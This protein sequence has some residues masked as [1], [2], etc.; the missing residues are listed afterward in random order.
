[1]LTTRSVP[2]P[3]AVGVAVFGLRLD[4]ARLAVADHAH[5]QHAGSHRFA[6]QM[7]GAKGLSQDTP[8][9]ALYARL[10]SLRIV[11]GPERTGRKHALCRHSPDPASR[12]PTRKTM[13]SQDLGQDPMS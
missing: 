11:D 1:M 9:A 13:S 12:N 3:D 2:A 5:R 8:L 10:R 4:E 7:H 6:I